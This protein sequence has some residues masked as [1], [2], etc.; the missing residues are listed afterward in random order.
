MDVP[1]ERLIEL[2]LGKVGFESPKR[3][4]LKPAR[5]SGH[6]VYRDVVVEG[7]APLTCTEE[8]AA[9][10][11]FWMRGSLGE[12]YRS[13]NHIYRLG[14]WSLDTNGLTMTITFLGP[15]DHPPSFPSA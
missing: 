5:L 7:R 12:H 9:H 15:V 10:I 11:E 8:M 13:G 3:V 6:R 1:T 2:I 4:T 14:P